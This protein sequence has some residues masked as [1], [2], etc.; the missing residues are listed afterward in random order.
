MPPEALH[1]AG[2]ASC[3]YFKKAK[4]VAQE[5]ANTGEYTFEN[6]HEFSTRDEYKN[7]LATHVQTVWVSNGA[8]VKHTTS[9]FVWKGEHDFIGGSSDLLALRKGELGAASPEEPLKAPDGSVM[10][11]VQLL[12]D[13]LKASMLFMVVSVVGR[14]PPLRNMLIGKMMGKIHEH[15]VKS[16]YSEEKLFQNAFDAP[17]AFTKAFY[18]MFRQQH[19]VIGVT[20]GEPCPNSKLI[21]LETG[22]EKPLLSFQHP[23]RPLILIFGSQS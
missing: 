16:A 11:L 13:I 15:D 18:K 19:A 5:L 17:W 6:N 12:I 14:I 2:F 22:R 7:W 4:V 1:V 8:A 23:G 20:V 10:Y 9:P 21:D 3:G